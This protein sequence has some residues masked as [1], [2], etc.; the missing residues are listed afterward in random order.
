MLSTCSTLSRSPYRCLAP[1]KAPARL[2]FCAP[3]QFTLP[4]LRRK[5]PTVL[6]CTNIEYKQQISRNE[7]SANVT[8][9]RDI[10]KDK[11]P[12][13]FLERAENLGF[14]YPTDVQ[15]QA[16]P[17]LLEGQDCILQSQTGSGKTLCYL[18]AILAKVKPTRAAVQAIV[19]VPTRELGMQ[20]V[21][22]ARKLGKLSDAEDK[23][24][25]GSSKETLNI[26][27]LLDGGSLSR[28]KVWLKADPPQ[29][30]VGTLTCIYKMIETKNLKTNAVNTLVIDEVDAMFGMTQHVALLRSLLTAF[31]PVQN[32]QT[33]LASATIPQHSQFIRKCISEKWVKGNVFHVQANQVQKMPETLVHRHVICERDEK[34]QMLKAVLSADLPKAAI[35]F[36]NE[37]SEASKRRGDL[38]TTDAVADYLASNYRQDMGSNFKPLVLREDANINARTSTLQDFPDEKNLL[39]ATDLAGRGLDIPEVTHVYNF[40]LPPTAYAYVHRGGRTARKPFETNQCTVTTFL[41]EKEFFVFERFQNEI[42]FQSRQHAIDAV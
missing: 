19:V 42:M 16:L 41:T 34:L 15:A 23:A 40:D 25:T 31:T 26:M 3:Q 27:S 4:S 24:K 10:C 29:I 21:R 22:E 32:R 8:T 12:E 2:K 18:F 33:I 1:C 39:I 6:A 5:S 35:I 37:Q 17:A 11:I 9:I 30:V 38:P 36:V 13:E 7:S 20:V 28:Q 14:V